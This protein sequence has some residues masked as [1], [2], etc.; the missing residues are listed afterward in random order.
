MR[1][2]GG[3]ILAKWGL[4]LAALFKRRSRPVNNPT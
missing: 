4:G 2:V 1:V 3:V